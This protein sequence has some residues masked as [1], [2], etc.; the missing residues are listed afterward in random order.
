MHTETRRNGFNP[1]GEPSPTHELPLAPHLF[2]GTKK[3]GTGGSGNFDPPDL[4]LLT[5]KE[6]LAAFTELAM[7]VRQSVEE[8]STGWEGPWASRP[9]FELDA[10]FRAAGPAA[11]ATL[12]ADLLELAERSTES[13]PA[14]A[15]ESV[16]RASRDL[17][18][19][20]VVV[21]IIGAERLV[22]SRH[23]EALQE[24]VF[25]ITLWP[26]MT[27][28]HNLP[29]PRTVRDDDEAREALDTL[30]ARFRHNLELF[31]RATLERAQIPLVQCLN[32]E[33]LYREFRER[34]QTLPMAPPDEEHPEIP[35]LYPDT[36]QSKDLVETCRHILGSDE[37]S[38][39]PPDGTPPSAP[40]LAP[41]DLYALYYHKL[42]AWHATGLALRD[43][44]ARVWE[45][46]VAAEV[47][48]TLPLYPERIYF[49]QGI[50][51]G[52]H[53]SPPPPDRPKA[54]GGALLGKVFL[55]DFGAVVEAD[56]EV[57]HLSRA[58]RTMLHE[59]GHCCHTV[60]HEEFKALSGWGMLRASE[61]ERLD[62]ETIRLGGRRLRSGDEFEQNGERLILSLEEHGA[63][64]HRSGARFVND[65]A[66]LSPFEDYAESL[67]MYH[68]NPLALKI[69]APEK[70]RFMEYV[71]GPGPR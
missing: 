13:T 54:Q 33:L 10:I 49:F 6:A 40:W 62:A 52:I 28:V 24:L 32:G 45:A 37:G 15:A 60:F 18:D 57:P 1:A 25:L 23:S 2:D 70:F 51:L 20:Q 42:S 38:A 30:E 22:L 5:R 59:I 67:T 66:S 44:P 58:A 55:Y 19:A 16:L 69:A 36:D 14:R 7:I 17:E 39:G 11:R 50:A 47:A 21:R 48:A 29:P 43:T 12:I 9:E 34:R 26:R 64:I 31:H 53:R 61:F 27:D 68:V 56:P 71:Y 35:S 8:R 4:K 3:G 41:A 65:Y 46:P 63:W